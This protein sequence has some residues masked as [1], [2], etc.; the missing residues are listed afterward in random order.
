MHTDDSFLL[1]I[2]AAP[3]DRVRRLVYADWLDERY[4]PRGELVRVEEE[5]RA[6]PVFADRFW[7]LKPRRNELRA[8]AGGD[9]CARMRYGTECEPEFRHGIPDGWRDRWRLIRE[10]TERWHRIPMPDVGGRQNEIA[11]AEARLKRELPQSLREWIAFAHDCDLPYPDAEPE[12]RFTPRSYFNG[13]MRVLPENEASEVFAIE[14]IYD[15]WGPGELVSFLE[16]SS[17]RYAI[18]PSHLSVP[19]PPANQY[20]WESSSDDYVFRRNELVAERPLSDCVL[21]FLLDQ[22]RGTL[23]HE[24]S[25]AFRAPKVVRDQLRR[26]IFVMVPFGNLKLWERPNCF[27]VESPDYEGTTQFRLFTADP[28]PES[29]YPTALWPHCDAGRPEDVI[30]F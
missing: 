3:A 21:R 4:D 25:A 14:M 10:F 1:A 17:T 2:E 30:P 9:W 26:H 20:V 18:S 19:D 11:E 22:T 16:R 8:V 7:E 6:L 12:H 15:G 24:A 13:E 23:S 28:I 27:V 5:M 29:E